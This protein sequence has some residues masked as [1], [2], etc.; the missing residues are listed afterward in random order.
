L[1]KDLCSSHPDEA[2]RFLS[3][4]YDLLFLEHYKSSNKLQTTI[5]TQVITSSQLLII[6][7][8]LSSVQPF[9]D[10]IGAVNRSY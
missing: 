4:V 1:I 10:F 7:P 5:L 8:S 2:L 3:K 9:L 6:L